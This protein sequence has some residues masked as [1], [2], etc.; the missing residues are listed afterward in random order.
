MHRTV[1]LVVGFM[2]FAGPAL[3][4]PAAAS[5]H[6]ALAANQWKGG[7]HNVNRAESKGKQASSGDKAAEPAEKG[8]SN[9]TEMVA[10]VPMEK[11][12]A[13]DKKEA[14]PAE[15]EAEKAEPEKTSPGEAPAEGAAP[16]QP[17]AEV[18]PWNQLDIKSKMDSGSFGIDLNKIKLDKF[19]KAMEMPKESE[20]IP[21]SLNDCIALAL[22]Q[23]QDIQIAELDPL[24]VDGNIM[25]AQ[26]ILDPVF[27]GNA[28]YTESE[29]VASSETVA[30][31]GISSIRSFTTDMQ[32]SINGTLPW[33]LQYS[34]GLHLNDDENT[35]NRFIE[36]WSGGLQL[37]LTQP[38]FRGR[39]KIATLARIREAKNSR[40]ASEATVRLTTMNSLSEVIQA[41]WDLVG[42]IENLRVRT[43]SVDNAE[44]LLDITQKRLK[45]GTA[46]PL[47][48]V[49]SQA[50]LATRQ[51]DLISAR[52]QVADSADRLK[53]MLN[54]QEHGV[55]SGKPIVP[56]DRP[57]PS[58]KTIDPDESIK[59]ALK[60]RPEIV[61]SQISIK[62]AEL[63]R[64]RAKNDMLPQLDVTTT[65]SQGGRGHFPSDVFD[66]I[67]TAADNSYS[68]SFTGSLPLRNRAA[69]G[70]YHTAEINEREAE[71]QLKKVKQDLVLNVRLAIRSV[72]TSRILV[73]STHQA[74]L[75][76][77]TNLS[78]EEQRLKLGLTTNYQVLQIEEDLTNAEV[79]EVQAQISLEKALVQLEL[80]QG[81][82][83]K[84]LGIKF[85]PPA[86]QKPVGY[87]QSVL[88]W[89]IP[90]KP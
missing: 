63:E 61:S 47:D 48:V 66:G 38:L 23:N 16:E 15:N 1:V 76:Q 29:Q 58:T 42:A 20:R 27:Q 43:K 6:G 88:P 28:V 13:Q 69:R 62:N 67:R 72:E 74:R 4:D 8:A 64:K 57:S 84:D 33:G 49:Q 73:E 79:Q 56:T 35:F 31:G 19:Y 14:A 78:A 25:S 46:A 12:E 37:R 18:K 80:A 90:P 77:E 21:L 17:P 2:L 53:R 7:V 59:D 34:L 55:L 24:K 22:K 75:V 81:T 40:I 71:A 3:A 54:M 68:V 32:S 65:V 44:R 60:F 36:E 26:G 41:Y 11:V 52:S 70:A 51:S 10:Q 50:G 39:G 87:I 86:P 5:S 30:F 83:L 82:L 45:I 9:G 85:E 89:Q